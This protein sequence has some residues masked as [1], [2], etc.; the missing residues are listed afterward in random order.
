MMR[1]LL[2]TG[3]LPSLALLLACAAGPT[4]PIGTAPPG[5]VPE[6]ALRIL[7]IGNSLTWWNDLPDLVAA[8]AVATDQ[9]RS[10]Y[11]ATVAFPDYSL[12]DHWGDGRAASAIASM[13]WDFVV[14]QQGPSSLPQ[15]REHLKEWAMRFA[16]S[17]R[18]AGAAPALYMVWPS[19]SRQQD[20]DGVL[21]AY[22]GAAEAVEGLFLPAGQAWRS[23]WARESSLEL[24]GP[25]GFHPSSLGSWLAALVIFARLYDVAPSAVPGSLPVGNST[26]HIPDDVLSVLRAAADDVLAA[27]PAS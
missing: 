2:D 17:I 3:W 20:F 9:E 14:M 26:L 4:A 10:P 23:A 5:E 18:A 27:W 16:P 13:E 6:N 11:V 19:A 7:F 8:M 12:E 25:D 24:Y 15:N 22:S 1:E 21:A